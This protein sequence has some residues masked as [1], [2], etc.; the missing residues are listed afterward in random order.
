MAVSKRLRYEILR[1]DNYTCRYCG[2][3]APAVVLVVDH[4]APSALGGRDDPSNL[5]ASCVDCN[6]GKSATPPD[7]ALVADVDEHATA[8]ARAVRAA[9]E[10]R[11]ADRDARSKVHDR[12]IAEWETYGGVPLDA[13]WRTTIDQNIDA[14]LTVGDLVELIPV[15]MGGPASVRNVWKYY[16]GC[17]KRRREEVLDR[18]AELMGA[19]PAVGDT[20]RDDLLAFTALWFLESANYYRQRGHAA[21]DYDACSV[22]HPGPCG[23]VCDL[24]RDVQTVVATDE[25][26]TAEYHAER[27]AAE[28]RSA[29]RS[30]M[31]TAYRAG[32]EAGLAEGRR[33]LEVTPDG[34]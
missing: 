15:A 27:S 17:L 26:G 13:A 2:A 18:A 11:T 21:A 30:G 25:R 10:E 22:D 34:A 28:A 33:S 7:A 31:K 1:R 5:V 23:P 14:G 3:A 19:P 8:W 32:F 16:C 20:D 4:V 6:S 24:V 29:R 12:F 9:A